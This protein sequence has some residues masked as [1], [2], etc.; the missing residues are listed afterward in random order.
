M[1]P[2]ILATPA[3]PHPQAEIVALDAAAGVVT[4]AW[5]DAGGA[6]VDSGGSLAR[7]TPPA[8]L[9]QEPDYAGPVQWPDI[10]DEVLVGAITALAAPDPAPVPDTITRAQFVIAAR[11]VLGLTE[12][13]VY[14][15]IARLPEGETQETA[16]DLWECA[17]EFRRSNTMLNTLAA[18]N[19]N[20]SEQLDEV[21]RV[22][23]GLNLD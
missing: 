10:A 18:L 9:P 4:F 3:A 20:T 8:P 14:A 15:L 16:R 17:R 2:R 6:R 12:G 11:R 19:G 1:S 7:F 5:L 22:G 21:F 13:A 23:A